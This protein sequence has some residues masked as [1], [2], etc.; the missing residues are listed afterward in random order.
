MNNNNNKPTN[1]SCAMQTSQNKHQL[2]L[3]EK[4]IDFGIDQLVH[5]HQSDELV[6]KHTHKESRCTN[7]SKQNLKEH[8]HQQEALEVAKNRVSRTK[9]LCKLTR[10]HYSYLLHSRSLETHQSFCNYSHYFHI[11]LRLIKLLVTIATT[12]TFT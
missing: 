4:S 10:K 8:N 12:F 2:G 5:F 6:T 7:I 3:G 1:H 11:H 9:V